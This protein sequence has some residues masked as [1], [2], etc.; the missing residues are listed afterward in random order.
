MKD[1]T[2]RPQPGNT[3]I[4][5]GQDLFS[6]NEYMYSQY[7]HSLHDGSLNPMSSFAPA[8]AMLYTD[9]ETLRG[10][11][12]PVDYGT[13]IEYG[14]GIFD[15]LFPNDEV[16]LQIGMWL[17]GVKGCDQIN[18]GQMDGQ[19]EKLGNYLNSC[20]AS[21]IFLRIGYE[22]DNPSFG[23]SEN[24]AAYVAAY[25]RIVLALRR[26]LPFQV[27]A[28]VKFVWHSWAA[29]RKDG[30]TLQGFYPGDDYVD[31]IGVSIFQQ[32]FP[33]A[34]YWGGTLRDIDEVLV[35]ASKIGKPTMIAESTPFGGINL[36]T[37]ETRAFNRT[38]SWDRWYGEVLMLIEKYDISMWCYINCDWDSQP[39]WRNIGFGDTR[40]SSNQEVM[41]KWDQYIINS[42]GEQH[43]LMSGSLDYSG[44]HSHTI[45]NWMVSDAKTLGYVSLLLAL[46]TGLVIC[47][48][49]YSCNRHYNTIADETKHLV[50]NE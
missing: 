41:E 32:V 8:A 10:L 6:I 38:N 47:C 49:K 33:W 15:S 19:I 16:G 50:P 42:A 17:N 39:M 7:N 1:S 12:K 27:I 11:D 18:G 3:Y 46:L 20:K 23:Y 45:K 29:P 44:D 31:W 48:R 37:S 21:V 34:S 35:F 40:L 26:E 24:P 22:F 4:V 25:Q 9:L 36:N 13:G 30:V 43:F 5:I 28:R 14:D 2:F